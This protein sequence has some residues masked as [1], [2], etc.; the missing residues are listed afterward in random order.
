LVNVSKEKA[1][2]LETHPEISKLVL[3]Q[4]AMSFLVSNEKTVISQE[5]LEKISR[6]AFQ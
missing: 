3:F 4:R 6:E 2:W 5:D 1:N